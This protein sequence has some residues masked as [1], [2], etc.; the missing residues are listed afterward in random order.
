[1]LPTRKPSPKTATLAMIALA[2]FV[3]VACSG[4]PTQDIEII[5]IDAVSSDAP[6]DDSL[7]TVY[8]ATELPY[9][10]YPNGSRYRVGG[11]NG[12]RIVVYQTEDSFDEVD[13]YYQ[14]LSEESGMP[15]LMAMNDYV[16]YSK[17]SADEDPWA[18]YRPGIVIHEFHDDSERQAVGARRDARTNIIM[19]F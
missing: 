13:A 9:P 17:D 14:D 1:M 18:T 4:E 7:T 15:R 2:S 6:G 3:A 19:S 10:V 16:R 11:E 8:G 12:L 5:E